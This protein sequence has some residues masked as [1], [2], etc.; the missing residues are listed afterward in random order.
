MPVSDSL[1]YGIRTRGVLSLGTYVYALGYPL[2]HAGMGTS[3]KFHDGKISSKVGY[4]GD[5]SQYQTTIPASPGYSGAPVFDGEGLLI[6]VLT[7]RHKLAEN[8]S[9]VVKVSSFSHLLDMLENFRLPEE[10]GVKALPVNQQVE[11]IAPY[12]V[13]IKSQ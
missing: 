10:S 11:R 12:V 3:I 1:P 8:A 9:Y 6:G 5:P 4:E 7:A 2:V 13:L